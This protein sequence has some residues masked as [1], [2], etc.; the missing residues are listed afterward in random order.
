MLKSYERLLRI[1]FKF[2][3]LSMATTDWVWIGGQADRGGE[4]QQDYFLRT[5][6]LHVMRF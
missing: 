5:R 6:D 4:S 2:Q 3:R 1:A